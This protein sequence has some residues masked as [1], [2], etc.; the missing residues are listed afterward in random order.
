MHNFLT[1]FHAVY[2]VL[3]A[4]KKLKI[5]SLYFVGLGKSQNVF[6]L[7]FHTSHTALDTFFLGEI[8]GYIRCLQ[9]LLKLKKSPRQ[10]QYWL[11]K[12]EK[13]RELWIWFKH[14]VMPGEIGEERFFL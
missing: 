3:N 13:G 5:C 8:L 11:K 10:N 14:F 9:G 4:S 1:E 12:D 2:S 6:C 7:T